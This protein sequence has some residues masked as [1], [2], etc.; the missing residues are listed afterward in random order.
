TTATGQ[1]LTVDDRARTIGE[2]GLVATDVPFD[3]GVVH[4]IDKVLMPETRSIAQL[5]VGSDRLQTLVAAVKAAG[6]VEQLGSENGPWTVFAPVDSAFARLPEGT[7][8]KL[9]E[10]GN[11]G[12][13][14]EILGLHVVPGRIAA[15]DLLA[16]K[17]LRTL[18]GAPIEVRLVDR[19]L[20]VGGARVLASDVQASN[21]VVH[22]IDTVITE[23]AGGG[24]RGAR[25]LTPRQPSAF[26]VEGAVTALYQVTINRGAKLW[27]AGNRDGCA[28][29][30]EVAI[31]SML[32]LGADRLPGELV[33]LL[34]EA[35][36]R[37]GREGAVQAAWTY[38]N[39]LDQAYRI[40]RRGDEPTDA[41]R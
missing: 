41:R 40:V 5:A 37:G 23:P 29:V 21:G 17:K 16:K 1:Q 2:A 7:V 18:M 9:L 8:E 35:R 10:R 36:E 26:D 30:Y 14:T 11:R 32:A 13:L 4:V 34:R 27:N 31:Q 28:A 6:L 12:T 39:A 24:D 33:D 25:G 20:T 38:R 22:L 19:E 3:G 15:R